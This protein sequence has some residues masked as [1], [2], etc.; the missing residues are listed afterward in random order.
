MGRFMRVLAVLLGVTWTILVLILMNLAGLKED[1][2][3]HEIAVS[4]SRTLFQLLVDMRSWN[5]RLGGIY[6]PVSD[7]CPPNEYLVHP[8]R[9]VVTRDGRKLTLV[10]PAYMT[11][12]VSEI[13]YEKHGIRTHLTSL[14]PIRPQNVAN[15]WEK[16]ALL[17]FESG[18]RLYAELVHDEDEG[19][20]FRY[21]E[22]L[23]QENACVSCHAAGPGAVVPVR[24][25]ISIVL[26]VDELVAS[27][28]RILRLN[29][30][31]FAFLWLMGLF[32]LAGLLMALDKLGC[33]GNDHPPYAPPP[34]RQGN[35]RSGL[36]K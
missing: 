26:P 33:A 14:D 34:S 2:L 27:R 16:E 19:Y 8:H 15:D 28:T 30:L 32:V 7:A 6:V 31:A 4:Q 11:R 20:L 9:D 22:P 21:M 23:R 29:R 12:Q 35:R 13:G 5:A 1:R 17:D 25:G 36:R 18:G 3:I 10:N 24:G